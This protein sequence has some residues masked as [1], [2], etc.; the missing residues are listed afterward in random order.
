MANLYVSLRAM[1]IA[2]FFENFQ[3]IIA[4]SPLSLNE[5]TLAGLS[6]FLPYTAITLISASEPY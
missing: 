2:S 4:L 5:S 3:S 6:I 1:A